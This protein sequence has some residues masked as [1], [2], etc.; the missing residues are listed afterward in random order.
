MSVN[1]KANQ[2]STRRDRLEPDKEKFVSSFFEEDALGLP[3]RNLLQRNSVWKRLGK[4]PMT[5]TARAINLESIGLLIYFNTNDVATKVLQNVFRGKANFATL[6][7]GV[8]MTLKD[9]KQVKV[10]AF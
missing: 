1:R 7:S 6:P 9:M 8:F 4:A 5:M 10:K 2:I 3:K